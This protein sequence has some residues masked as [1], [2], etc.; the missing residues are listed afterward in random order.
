MHE[1]FLTA[2][3]VII[4]E[5]GHLLAAYCLHVPIVSFSLKPIGASLTFDFSGASYTSEAV[6]HF[7]GPFFG[8]ISAVIAYAVFG[9]S[10][11]YFCGI[12]VVLAALNLIPISGFDGG[13]ILMSLLS[14]FF[15]PDVVWRICRALSFVFLIILWACVLWIELR[16]GANFSLLAYVLFILLNS[17]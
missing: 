6:I 14:V 2:I 12:S 5:A 9:H 11:F 7:F 8:F 15:M 16:I 3:A 4:H 1:L 13:A 10:A 17:E